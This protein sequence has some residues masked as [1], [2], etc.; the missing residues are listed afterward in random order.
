ML[1]TYLPSKLKRRMAKAYNKSL[2]ANGLNAPPI[3]AV[4]FAAASTPP[5]KVQGQRLR[6]LVLFCLLTTAVCLPGCSIPNLE[7]P[8]CTEAQQTVKELYSY[9][10]GNDMKF[11]KENLQQRVKFLSSQLAANLE[12]KDESANDYFTATDDYPK[13]FRVGG[14]KVIEPEKRVSFGVLLFWKTDVRSEQR[15]IHVEA[16][17]ENG[18]WL[19]NKVE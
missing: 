2:D 18:E 5:F 12:Q 4:R 7:K 11:T 9:H 8:E 15:E 1:I 13:A 6:K 17:K 19:V 10:F 16:V 3:K 14:C